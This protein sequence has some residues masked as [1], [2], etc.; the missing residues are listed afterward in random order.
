[1]FA[2]R[3]SEAELDP[4]AELLRARCLNDK[5]AGESRRVY[6]RCDVRRRLVVKQIIREQSELDGFAAES[7]VHVDDGL[8]AGLSE[9]G[10]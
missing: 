8:V 7:D 6:K 4:S 1:M 5:G 9:V 10:H 2:T 3:K